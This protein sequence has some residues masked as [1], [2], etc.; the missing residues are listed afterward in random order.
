MK[1]KKQRKKDNE[2]WAVSKKIAQLFCCLIEFFLDKVAS[3][4]LFHAV[5]QQYFKID[6]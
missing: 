3:K 4:S 6:F 2:N 5:F 1:D